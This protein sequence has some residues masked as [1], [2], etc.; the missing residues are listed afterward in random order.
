MHLHPHPSPPPPSFRVVHPSSSFS[1]L[2]SL[3][4]PL[5][6]FIMR[7]MKLCDQPETQEASNCRAINYYGRDR[8]R[9]KMLAMG[10]LCSRISPVL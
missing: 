1:R 8:E 9:E 4:P 2:S 7:E 5:P 10:R 3:P 6:K